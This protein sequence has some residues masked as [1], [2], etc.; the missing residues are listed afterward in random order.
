MVNA[1]TLKKM[2]ERLVQILELL[3]SSPRD[4]FLLFAA[5]KEYEKME[6]LEEALDYYALLEQSD[7]AY[8]GLYYHLGKLL[9]KL[10]R[11]QEALQAYERGI[12]VAQAQGDR[13]SHSELS[14]AKLNLELGE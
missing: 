1:Q 11:E 9:E 4:S 12:H 3:D 8:V 5:A 7:P 6:D 10:G 2:S 14:G 13:H